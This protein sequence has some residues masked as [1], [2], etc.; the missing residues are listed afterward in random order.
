M[1]NLILWNCLNDKRF[2][3]RTLS[4]YQLAS[5][6]RQHG[7]TVKVIDFCHLMST[8]DLVAITEKHIGTD[9]LAIGVSSTFWSDVFKW[10]TGEPEWILSA[11]ARLENKN[12]YWLVGGSQAQSENFKN[13][14]VR[15]S[16]NAEDELLKWMDNNSSKLRFRNLFDIK[17]ATTIFSADDYI[18]PSEVLPIEMGRGCQFKC[19]FCS[20]PLVGKKKGT[21]MKDFSLI[22]EEFIR[23]YNEFGTTKYYVLDD[24]A[25]ESEEKVN[26]LADIVQSLPFELSW[27][28]YNR[29]DLIWSRP[30]TIQTLKDSGLK[31]SF[32]GIESFHPE[33]SMAIGKGWNGKH[34][35]EFL[36]ELKDKWKTDVTWGLS[37]IVG[38]PGELAEHIEETDDWCAKNGMYHWNFYPLSINKFSGKVWKS[39]FEL[40]HE[41]YG[42]TFPG[43]QNVSWVSDNWTFGKAVLYTQELNKRHYDKAHLVSWPL[44]ELSSLGYSINE[45]MDKKLVQHPWKRYTAETSNFIN[46]Y[47]QHQLAQVV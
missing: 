8:D 4:C 15:F 11:R 29:L 42:Y 3:V 14:W 38:L 24:T 13:V 25:N 16:G 10:N 39:E 41:K 40:E 32:F 27:T 17:S 7:Y 37:F 23:N 36:L 12:L 1:A 19:R 43:E 22:R 45:L 20:Y 28:G 18:R 46:E 47:T 9:T 33:A 44:F 30:N 6:L 21:Y 26:A 34:G 31:S 35:K 5:W 2:P